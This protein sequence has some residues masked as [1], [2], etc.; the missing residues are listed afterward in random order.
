VES[1]KKDEMGN[2][3]ENMMFL[4]E[5]F[6]MQERNEMEKKGIE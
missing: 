3:I 4:L 1:Q 2:I 5:R 6:K